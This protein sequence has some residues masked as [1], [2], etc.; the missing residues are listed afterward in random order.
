MPGGQVPRN[1]DVLRMPAYAESLRRI[2]K[3]G[4]SVMYD[5][6]IG[7]AIGRFLDSV[8]GHHVPEDIAAHTCNWVEPAKVGTR[9][10]EVCVAPPNS[11][12]ILH[13]MGF[14][15]LDGFELGEAPSALATHLQVEALKV[16]YR[17]RP[18]IA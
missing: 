14:A 8:G 13:S 15:L 4:P 5:G 11:Q 9:G 17:E 10:Y 18:H 2:A 12:A 16:S 7:Q 1:G 3:E 6:A